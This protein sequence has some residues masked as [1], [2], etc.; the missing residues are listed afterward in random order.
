M[1][2]VVPLMPDFYVGDPAS[3]ERYVD[4]ARKMQGVVGAF[5]SKFGG[6]STK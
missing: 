4:A 3:L 1:S 2:N 5:T 6:G